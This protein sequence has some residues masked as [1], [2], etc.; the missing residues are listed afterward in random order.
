MWF[1]Q[2]HATKKEATL[3]RSIFLD[4]GFPIRTV[5]MKLRNTS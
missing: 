2:I 1:Q 3:K 4:I 5:K